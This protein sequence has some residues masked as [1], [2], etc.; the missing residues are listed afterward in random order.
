MHKR[1]SSRGS[2]Y[3]DED[4]RSDSSFVQRLGLRKKKPKKVGTADFDELFARGMAIS[5]TL[6][7]KKEKRKN[8]AYEDELLKGTAGHARYDEHGTRF[9]PF[10]VYSHEDAFKK[11]QK[12]EGIGYAEKVMC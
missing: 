7:T 1:T 12:E 2:N 4:N 5:A 6:E 3:D 10:E 8:E 9:T 11:T